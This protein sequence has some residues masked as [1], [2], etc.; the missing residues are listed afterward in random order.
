MS[1]GKCIS[2]EN[3]STKDLVFGESKKGELRDGTSFEKIPI[4]VRRP[5]GFTGP[6]IIVTETCFSFGIQRDTK[7]D[8]FT[9]P[10]VLH[11]KDEP[12]HKQKLFVKTIRDILSVCEPK[13][14]S[15]LYGSEENPIMYL[16]LDYDKRCGVFDTKFCERDTMENK[17]S[18]K[19]I[20][21]EKYVGKYCLAKV[22]VRIDS[23]FVANTTTLQIRAHTV[24]L[25]ETKCRKPAD[26]DD[27]LDE[28]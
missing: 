3:F 27:V 14:K 10:L 12:T 5:D 1:S 21:P 26:D 20:K 16:K 2:S 13:P 8:T 28:M 15:C 22:A 19:K 9:I 23:V 7:Y 6:L 4:S 24:I 18:T 25:S 11:D 17:D